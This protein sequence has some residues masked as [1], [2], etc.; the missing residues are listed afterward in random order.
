MIV[1]EDEMDREC[2]THGEKRNALRVSMR[3]P[4]G[5]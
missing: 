5:K 2:S 4:E 3:E 1:K